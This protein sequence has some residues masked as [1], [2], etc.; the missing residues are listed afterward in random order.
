MTAG[1]SHYEALIYVMVTMSAV[2]ADMT[3][4]ELSRIGTIVNDLPSF[5]GFNADDLIPIAQSCAEQLGADGGLNRVLDRVS[6]SLPLQLH[7]T[8]YALAVEVAVADMNL[9]QEEL[10]F[11]EL[12][13]DALGLDKLS[14]A[15]IER[16][17]RARYQRA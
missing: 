13:R 15:A 7:E 5:S 10:R 4:D 2:D 11:L 14:T 3:D 17:A 1:L 16:G 6:G 12:L 9:K 8:A